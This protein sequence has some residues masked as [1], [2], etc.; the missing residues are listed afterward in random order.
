MIPKIYIILIKTSTTAYEDEFA[1][2][3]LLIGTYVS[4]AK[5]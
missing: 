5:D 1:E 4:L 3:K 2:I